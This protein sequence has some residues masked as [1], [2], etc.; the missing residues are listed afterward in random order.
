M[1]SSDRQRANG[2]FGSSHV[3][4]ISRSFSGHPLDQKSQ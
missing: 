4:M 2:S 3:A 1:R